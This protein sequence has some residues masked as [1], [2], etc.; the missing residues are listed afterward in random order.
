MTHMQKD[1]ASF[2]AHTLANASHFTAFLRAGPNV[3]IK[4]EAIPTRDDAVQTAAALAAEHGRNALIYAVTGEGRS[5][6]VGYVTPAGVF[7]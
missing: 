6:M 3:R 1:L 2:E 7:A 4:V 5:T